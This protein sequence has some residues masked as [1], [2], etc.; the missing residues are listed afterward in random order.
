MWARMLK[1]SLTRRTVR[2]GERDSLV[3]FVYCNSIGLG[4]FLPDV[5][6]SL[7]QDSERGKEVPAKL[8]LSI[9]HIRLCPNS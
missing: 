8:V 9:D 6:I 3:H 1:S 5:S 7:S 4:I 2:S